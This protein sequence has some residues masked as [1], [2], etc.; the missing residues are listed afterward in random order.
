M[1]LRH[2]HEYSQ[3]LEAGFKDRAKTSIGLF[4]DSFQSSDEIGRW[5]HAYLTRLPLDCDRIRHE[6][7]AELVYPTLVRWRS[8]GNPKGAFWLGRLYQNL[9]HVGDPGTHRT[10]FL[11]ESFRLAP[12]DE[13]I[14]RFL[15]KFMLEDFD[16]L[17][18]E[19]PSGLIATIDKKSE[20][21]ED[22]CFVRRI[23]LEGEYTARWDELEKRIRSNE[24]WLWLD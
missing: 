23:D 3:N 5:V 19:W 8:A 1:E 16:L 18:H 10:D 11:K 13:D 12:K 14:R 2:W 9:L 24:N 17:D 6:I 15:L 4:I 22:V 21:L 20:L 7:F